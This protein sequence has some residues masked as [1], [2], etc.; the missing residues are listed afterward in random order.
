MIKNNT[1]ISDILSDF[2]FPSIDK[3]E[4]QRNGN[5]LII[6]PIFLDRKDDKTDLFNR[7]LSDIK[8]GVSDDFMQ[9]RTQPLLDTRE[10]I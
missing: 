2:G 3:V 7:F 5:Y 6:K 9:A 1:Q 10:E 4:I 8:G